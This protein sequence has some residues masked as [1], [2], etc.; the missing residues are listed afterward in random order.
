[1]VAG[2]DIVQA[3]LLGLSWRHTTRRVGPSCKHPRR[4]ISMKLEVYNMNV[5]THSLKSKRICK[6][7]DWQYSFCVDRPTMLVESW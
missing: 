2:L 3:Q 7:I 6:I 5:P 1:V 4:M